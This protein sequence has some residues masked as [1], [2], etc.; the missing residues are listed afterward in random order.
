MADAR[1]QRAAL[2]ARIAAE[3][4]AMPL[5]V[6][7][8]GRTTLT[9]DKVPGKT[10]KPEKRTRPVKAAVPT[11]EP[12]VPAPV[13]KVPRQPVTLRAPATA[14]TAQARAFWTVGD[15]LTQVRAGYSLE[16]VV[17][18]TGYSEQEIRSIGRW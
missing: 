17:A 18:R 5:S 1:K 8:T 10:A 4:A 12:A 15:A 2:D 3:T 11:P 9:F 16:R 14:A 7:P 6:T 13:V